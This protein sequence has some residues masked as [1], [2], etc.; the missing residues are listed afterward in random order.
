MIKTAVSTLISSLSDIIKKF[1]RPF[2]RHREIVVGIAT[3]YWLEGPGIKFRWRGDFPPP[4]RPALE[5]T[6]PP[7][8]RVPGLPRG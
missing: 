8:K 6:L 7:I 4:S 2:A 3:G 5:L 1:S